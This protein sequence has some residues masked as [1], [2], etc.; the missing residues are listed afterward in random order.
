MLILDPADW[1][2]RVLD[3]LAAGVSAPKVSRRFHA[4]F[5]QVLAAAAKTLAKAGRTKTICLSGGSFQNRVLLVGLSQELIRLGFKVHTN[6]AI[7]VNDGGLAFGQAVVADA[8]ARR[9]AK[10]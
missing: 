1:L 9:G 3:D 10:Q 5:I 2:K 6:R 4:T 8:C 7:P